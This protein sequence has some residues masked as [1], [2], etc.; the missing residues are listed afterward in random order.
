MESLQYE[1]LKKTMGTTYLYL[2]EDEQLFTI[3]SKTRRSTI[4]R[5][6]NR[7]CDNTVRIIDNI[8]KRKKHSDH[9]L[10]DKG[11]NEYVELKLEILLKNKLIQNLYNNK[12]IIEILKEN[13][14]PVT[15]MWR[16]KLQR[17][18][19]KLTSRK[20]KK[21]NT[22]KAKPNSIDKFSSTKNNI[23]NNDL[24]TCSIIPSNNKTSELDSTCNIAR[25][26]L[27][28]SN[29]SNDLN[30][31]SDSYSNSSDSC[32]TDFNTNEPLEN[33]QIKTIFIKNHPRINNCT[34]K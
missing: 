16:Y 23:S 22:S 18:K 4:F 13:N 25:D 33:F 6:K 9:D 29:S 10:K 20:T 1:V 19:E 26:A 14:L 30:M 15:S 8:C 7:N 28:V 32:S 17:L 12:T 34:K 11:E 27:S 3:K 2:I 24:W 5:C 21:I 31:C